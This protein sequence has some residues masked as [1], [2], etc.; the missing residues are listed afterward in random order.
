MTIATLAVRFLGAPTLA[1]LVLVAACGG[2]DDDQPS[3]TPTTTVVT[4]APTTREPG[5]AGWRT[6]STGAFAIDYPPDWSAKESVFYS[7]NPDTW[8]TPD[9]PPENLAV[10]V[11]SYQAAGTTECG[12]ALTVDRT[13]GEGTPVPE[14]VATTLGG[15]EAWEV[16]RNGVDVLYT[17]INIIS[18]I[19]EGYCY[20]VAGYSTYAAPDSELFHQI[21]GTFEFNS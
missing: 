14:A 2:D 3:P 21:A 1:L 9:Q 7:S 15:L 17:Q 12:W 5:V 13:T 20:S 6:Y 11:G 4:P 16:V 18:R 10:A 8:E 19:H